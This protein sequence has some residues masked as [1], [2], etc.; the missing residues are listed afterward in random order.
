MAGQSQISYCLV[1]INTKALV[2]RSHLIRG[3]TGLSLLHRADFTKITGSD[4]KSEIVSVKKS[5]P[6]HLKDYFAQFAGIMGV[7]Q[8]YM[9]VSFDHINAL[10]KSGISRV[11]S[12]V[13]LGEIFTTPTTLQYGSD[14]KKN[15]ARRNDLGINHFE[16]FC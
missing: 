7:N 11:A 3:G 4:C 12:Y 15:I 9:V 13:I 8:E 16:F 1:Y 14:I 6:F 5:R 10:L 2:T